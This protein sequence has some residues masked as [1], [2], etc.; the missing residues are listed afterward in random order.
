MFR[1]YAALLFT[2]PLV[3][4]GFNLIHHFLIIMSAGDVKVHVAVANVSIA[5]AAHDV[6]SQPGFHSLNA[7][8][9]EKCNM[10]G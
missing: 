7:V 3:K 2:G 8:F 9:T 6:V 5:N 1:T 10:Y 4:I